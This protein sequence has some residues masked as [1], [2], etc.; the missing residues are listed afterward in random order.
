MPKVGNREFPYTDKGSGQ[1]E[2]Y[3]AQ[4]GQ[5][6]SSDK[7]SYG[8]GTEQGDQYSGER[9]TPTVEWIPMTYQGEKFRF[10][11]TAKSQEIM[12]SGNT[13]EAFGKLF[14][15]GLIVPEK[16]RDSFGY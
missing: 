10:A 8:Y 4:T 12:S 15:L 6:V 9:E 16:E 13:E 14:A 5:T 7:D 1:A 11:N 3:A 2:V